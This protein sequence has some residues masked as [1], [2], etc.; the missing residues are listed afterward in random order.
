MPAY[1]IA[2]TA[3]GWSALCVL[4][5]YLAHRHRTRRTITG[6]T[7]QIGTLIADFAA[8]GPDAVEYRAQ[9]VVEQERR[10]HA[11]IARIDD[12]YLGGAA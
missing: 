10:Y 12:Y 4:V 1:L 2:L 7:A 11:Q 8:V 6:L 9:I 3:A 5:G